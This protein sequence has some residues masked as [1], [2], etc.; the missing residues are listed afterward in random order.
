MSKTFNDNRPFREIVEEIHGEIWQETVNRFDLRDKEPEGAL[1]A[2]VM[3]YDDGY[4]TT[5][6]QYN[7]SPSDMVNISVELMTSGVVQLINKLLEAQKTSD[8]EDIKNMTPLDICEA[9]IDKA[10]NVLRSRVRH[11]VT[12]MLRNRET[13]GREVRTIRK[14]MGDTA[15]GDEPPSGIPTDGPIQ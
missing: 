13:E 1:I 3:S 14:D 9:G 5:V 12:D 11:V 15:P 8:D 2:N 7:L 6:A 4:V 10:T